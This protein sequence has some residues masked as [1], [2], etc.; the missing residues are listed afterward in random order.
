MAA[1]GERSPIAARRF[2]EDAALATPALYANSFRTVEPSIASTGLRTHA[3]RSGTVRRYGDGAADDFLVASRL[4]RGD[5]EFELSVASYF[6]EEATAMLAAAG[7]SSGRKA[8]T[9]ELPP[10]PPLRMA[11]GETIRRRRSVRRYT[12]DSLPLTYL[13]AIVRGACGITGFS[14]TAD[15]SHPRIAFRTTPSGGGLY[16]VELQVAALR[17]DGLSRGVYAYDPPADALLRL[18]GAETVDR[19][20]NAVAAPDQ[21]IRTS[22]ACAICLLVARPRRATRKYGERGMRHVFLEAG[23]IAQH[24]NLAAVALGIGSVDSSSLYDD[25]AHDALDMD[26]V[27]EAL[28]HSVILGIPA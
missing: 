2:F 16:P 19:L 27:S 6:S 26:G 20:M 21:A 28:V 1:K 3:L 22:E 18:G 25:E 4:V 23:A 9:I 5:V 7:A 11:L 17:V 10:S 12:G 14:G 24:I 8:E 13:A 15:D